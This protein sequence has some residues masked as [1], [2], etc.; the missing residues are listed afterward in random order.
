M[1]NIGLVP[2]LIAIA[3]LALALAKRDPPPLA[4]VGGW[5]SDRAR[6]LA[7][8]LSATNWPGA[9][10]ALLLTRRGELWSIVG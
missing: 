4:V 1:V 3:G 5:S 6:E 2:L 8:A 7:D 10:P 9:K